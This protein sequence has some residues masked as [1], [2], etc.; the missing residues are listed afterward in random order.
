[1]KTLPIFVL[2][3]ALLGFTSCEDVIDVDLEEGETQLNVDAWVT[4]EAGAQNI[5]LSLTQA[6]FDN[7]EPPPALGANVR[8]ED[9]EGNTYVFTDDNED[10]IY[11][12]TPADPN[13]VLGKIGNQY[14]LKIAYQ[15]ENYEARSEMN[16]VPPIDSIFYEFRE[17]EFGSVDG[18]YAQLYAR[19]LVGSGDCYW[20]RAFKNGQYLNKPEDINVA[21]DAGFSQGG[22]VD[23]LVFIQPIREG[24]NPSETDENDEE[25][26]PYALGDNIRVELYSITPDAFFFFQE[27]INQLNNGGLF[28][29]PASNVSTNIINTNPNGKAAVGYFG[30][31]AVSVAET[32][33]EE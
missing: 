29:I 6:Y 33:I 11:T 27:V 1:M 14:T 25:I 28:A 3:V 30:A 10:G 18:Y 26:A 16:R 19:D 5:R 8:V 15:G 32:V 31:S 23:G 13:D 20:I 17:D 2:F 7:T 4:N 24:I 22:N 12:W 9:N 21:Y